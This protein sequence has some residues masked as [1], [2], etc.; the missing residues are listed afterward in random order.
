MI[1]R[2]GWAAQHLQYHFQQPELLEQ[3]LTHRSA[4]PQNNERLEFL[5]DSLLNF[6]VAR[7]LYELA[8]IGTGR[9]SESLTL[10]T[11]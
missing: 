5:G 8:S 4:S 11:G 6:A 10:G 2:L 1:D 9:K 7:R 3:A